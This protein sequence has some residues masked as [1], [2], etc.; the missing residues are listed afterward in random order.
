MLDFLIVIQIDF[1]MWEVITC[2][3]IENFLE[4]LKVILFIIFDDHLLG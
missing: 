3:L 2:D 4:E 1:F